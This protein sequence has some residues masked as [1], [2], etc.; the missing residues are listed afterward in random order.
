[1]SKL[2]L[3]VVESGFRS[4][5]IPFSD[6][7][8]DFEVV[9]IPGLMKMKK[10]LEIDCILFPANAGSYNGIISKRGRNANA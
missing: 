10:W 9:V 2:L 3:I 6:G 8:L 4:F 7:R 1:L 5:S